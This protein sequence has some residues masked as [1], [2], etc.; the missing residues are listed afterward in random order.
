M[1]TVRSVVDPARVSI[2]GGSAGGYTTLQSLVTTRTYTAG[3]S[4][5]GIGDLELLATDTHKFESRYLDGLIG[6]LPEAE[7]RAKA[8][9]LAPTIRSI[10][11][12]DAH[13]TNGRAMVGHFTDT[14]EV[15]DFLASSEHPRLAG[16]GTS[17]PDHF[18]RTKVKPL[19]MDL[20]PAD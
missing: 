13:A 17:C 3:V 16:L 12:Q 4:R 19:L 20:P 10:A 15:L 1:A 9:A 5:Y 18:L 8:A 7:R 2:T 11:S 14:A 6:P